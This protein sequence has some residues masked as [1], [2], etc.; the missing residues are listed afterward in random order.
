M[1]TAVRG[2]FEAPGEDKDAPGV[3]ATE[4]KN[5]AITASKTLPFLAIAMCAYRERFVNDYR[6]GVN[7]SQRTAGYM[8]LKDTVVAKP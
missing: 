5:I 2:V 1:V 8:P 6:L 3:D 4:N 7:D